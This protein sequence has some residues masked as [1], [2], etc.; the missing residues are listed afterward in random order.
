MITSGDGFLVDKNWPVKG[1]FFFLQFTGQYPLI[2]VW[3]SQDQVA[4]E[5]IA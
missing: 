1:V 5:H 2:S 3:H 4:W